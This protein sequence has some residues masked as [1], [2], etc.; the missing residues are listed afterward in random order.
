MMSYSLIV[1]IFQVFVFEI[2]KWWF[3]ILWG[4]NSELWLWSF[5]A[6]VNIFWKSFSMI[7]PMAILFVLSV[8]W[9]APGAVRGSV[10]TVVLGVPWVAVLFWLFE[11][12]SFWNFNILFLSWHWW[13]FHLF[14]C[15]LCLVSFLGDWTDIMS[16]IS[17]KDEDDDHEAKKM[18][19]ILHHS[20]LVFGFLPPCSPSAHFTESDKF[21]EEEE[22]EGRQNLDTIIDIKLLSCEEWIWSEG[23]FMVSFWGST[24][25]HHW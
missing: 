4:C 3:L 6:R 10:I 24:N 8:N 11:H 20:W 12:S 18:E 21:A 1:K 23:F 17:H 13:H 14:K 19:R 2:F 16:L 22:S 25:H 7:N 5:R 9:S 15:L